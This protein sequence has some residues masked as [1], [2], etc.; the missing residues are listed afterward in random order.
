[1]IHPD[2]YGFTYASDADWDRGAVIEL[3]AAHPDHAWILTDRDC[4]YPNP[5]YTG[6]K[7]RHPEDDS[8]DGED[9]EPYEPPDDCPW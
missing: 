3:G 6:P 8:E 2:D 9:R 4:W 5:F 1:M 7:V